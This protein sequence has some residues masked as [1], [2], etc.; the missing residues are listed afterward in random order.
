MVI[1]KQLLLAVVFIDCAP[2]HEL[3]FAL[4]DRARREFGKGD[5]DLIEELRADPDLRLGLGTDTPEHY[6][7]LEGPKDYETELDFGSC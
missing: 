1:E 3:F 4:E 7:V 2:Y 6:F 5:D